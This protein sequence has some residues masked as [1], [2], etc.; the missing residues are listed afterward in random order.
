MFKERSAP[1]E[2]DTLVVR[3]GSRPT[4]LLGIIKEE[5]NFSTFFFCLWAVG[6]SKLYLEIKLIFY[7]NNLAAGCWAR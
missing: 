5:L 1:G 4:N 3:F 2:F 7:C 6:M